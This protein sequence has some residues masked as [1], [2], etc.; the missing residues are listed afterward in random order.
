MTKAKIKDPKKVAVGRKGG[1]LSPTNFSRNREGAKAAGQR[2]AW[3]RQSGKLEDYP[4][5]LIR[6]D[7]GL[8]PLNDPEVPP[9]KNPP[10]R[11]KT[12]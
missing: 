9:R 6:P 8:T 4:P 11:R 5:L 2:S 12:S 3:A 7:G 10:L 1:K